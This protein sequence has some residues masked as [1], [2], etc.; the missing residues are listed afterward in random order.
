V[1]SLKAAGG[2]KLGI[3]DGKNVPISQTACKKNS[4]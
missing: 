1:A 4:W 3:F 2:E